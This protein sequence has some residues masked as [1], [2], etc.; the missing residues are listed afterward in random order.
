MKVT[1][2]VLI[3]DNEHDALELV[4]IHLRLMDFPVLKAPGGN[5]AIDLITSGTD[6][7]G[8]ILLDLAMPDPNGFKTCAAIRKIPG[9]ENTPIIAMTALHGP[10]VEEDAI[11]AGF[12]GFLW[13]PFSIKD[14]QRVLTEH[15]LAY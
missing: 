6:E 1:R 2:A 3:V 12:T 14:I 11:K 7:I 8:L 4:G 15:M 13:K 10:Q 5:E 9:F